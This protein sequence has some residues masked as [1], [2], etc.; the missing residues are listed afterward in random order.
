MKRDERT[1][2]HE[3]FESGS[4]TMLDCEEKGVFVAASDNMRMVP[5]QIAKWIPGGLMTL[6]TDGYGRSE[7]R[8]NLR[9]FFEVSAEHI[10]VATLYKLHLNDGLPKKTVE[11]AIK[12]LGINTKQGFSLYR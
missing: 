4:T 10:T 1:D 6:G 3:R 5:D 9:N 12:D 11:K 7:T 2:R 8:E